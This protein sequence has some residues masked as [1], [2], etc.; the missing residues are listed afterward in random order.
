MEK[1]E[2]MRQ[3]FGAVRPVYR[4]TNKF[5]AG[6]ISLVIILISSAQI[7]AAVANPAF[8]QEK[9][10]QITTGTSNAVA[11]ASSTTAGN[12]IVI[13]LIWDNTGT[14]AVTDSLRNTYVSTGPALRWSNSKYSAQIFYA[15]NGGRG[16]DTVTATFSARINLF[17]IAYAHEYSGISTSAPLDVTASATGISGSLNSG[18]A[19]TTTAPDLL[20]AGGV[21]AST[22]TAPGTGFIARSRAQGNMT[23]DRLVTTQGAYS[24]TASNGGGAWCLQMVAFHGAM[25]NGA[26][27]ASPKRSHGLV[28]KSFVFNADRIVLDCF[29]R[30]R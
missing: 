30:R 19:S 17:G 24:A 12:L 23:E 6:F 20:F 15:I 4:A 13:Y 8:V 29:Q 3:Y 22:V 25:A 11:F 21:S 26:L 27:D 16:A 28:R 5:F 2:P 10:K 9:D 18:A 7:S 14:A 1:E